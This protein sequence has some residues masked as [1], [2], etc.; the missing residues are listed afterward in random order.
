MAIMAPSPSSLVFNVRRCE[1]KLVVPAK[2]TPHEFKQLSDV[3]DQ[4]RHHVLVIM[5]YRYE[6]SLE[7]K[8]P[9]KFC[10]CTFEG[11]SVLPCVVGFGCSNK[12]IVF[13]QEKRCGG[14]A[15]A[16]R[17]NH[18]M[19]DDMSIRQS[20]IA[21]GEMAQ[22]ASAPS[23]PPVWSRPRPLPVPSMTWPAIVS[24]LVQLRYLQFEKNS[25]ICQSLDGKKSDASTSR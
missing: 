25:P 2:S 11:S 21:V 22:G 24:S 17:Y 12:S 14:F 13:K 6:Q 9:V 23:I 5:F 15:L 3:D 18:I 7:G 20:M 10:G 1:P 4:E 8:D 16:L 19:S